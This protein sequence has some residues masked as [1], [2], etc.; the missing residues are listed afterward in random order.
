MSTFLAILVC[1]ALFVT[2][3]WLTR[4]RSGAPAGT[5]AAARSCGACAHPCDESEHDDVRPC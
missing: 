3:G 5:D 4:E 1:T 2:L